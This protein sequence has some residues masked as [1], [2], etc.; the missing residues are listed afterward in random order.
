M[1]PLPGGL[2]RCKHNRIKELQKD[3][4]EPGKGCAVGSAG[5]AKNFPFFAPFFWFVA[6][7]LGYT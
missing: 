3:G 4:L 7:F 6:R 5:H 2:K 1:A